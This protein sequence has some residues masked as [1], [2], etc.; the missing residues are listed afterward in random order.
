MQLPAHLDYPIIAIGD[1]H[2][3][4]EFLDRL[5]AR[6]RKLPEWPESNLVFLGDFVDRG[7]NVRGCVE[8]VLELFE[9]KPGSSA[10]VGNHDFGMIHAA[11]I[12]TDPVNYWI[13]RW[14]VYTDHTTTFQSYLGR[15]P[16][17]RDPV[18]WQQDLSDLREAMPERHRAFFASLHWVVEAEG[19][20]FLHNGLS[21]ELDEPAATQL[22]LLRQKKWHDYVTPKFGTLSMHEYKPE[23]P[24]W[25]GADRSLSARPLPLHDRVL[26]SG[27][28]RVDQPEF[29]SVRIRIDTSGGIREPLTACLLRSATSD[30]IFIPSKD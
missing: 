6:L 5:I 20:V 1:L 29:N 2:G 11:G 14:A 8:R 18:Q 30:P 19:H 25:L 4:L 16:K 28:V 21:P 15:R 26:V 24:V 17:P 10:V 22:E 27:H 23:Y 12:G 9:E 13:E 3:Q 7:P